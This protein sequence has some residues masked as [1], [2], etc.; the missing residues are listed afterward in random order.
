[1][2][3]TRTLQDLVRETVFLKEAD[4]YGVEVTDAEVAQYIQSI[5]AFQHDGK[6]DQQTYIQV[7][8][9]VIHTPPDEF[10][11]ERR[12][13]IKIQKL[14]MILASAVKI[15]DIEFN[16]RFQKKMAETAD[17]DAKKKL[18]DNPDAFREDLRRE[19]V[20][21]VF[22]EWLTAINAQLKVKS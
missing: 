7:L 22:N 2:V 19:E 21:Q 11:D 3:R 17:A 18:T 10:E 14:Q 6:F 16:W 5:P 20:N 4:K 12:K 15:G 9:Q 1:D 8:Y 13:D